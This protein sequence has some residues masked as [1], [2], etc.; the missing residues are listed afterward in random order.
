MRKHNPGW[1]R[2]KAADARRGQYILRRTKMKVIV[3][4]TYEE[5]AKIKSGI[6][7]VM[8]VLMSAI[9]VLLCYFFNEGIDV[10]LFQLGNQ[11]LY[12]IKA[13]NG[14]AILLMVSGMIHSKLLSHIGRHSKELMILHHPPFFFISSLSL[15]LSKLF[16]P[17]I[18]G[19]LI[20]TA[21]TTLFCL[22]IDQIMGRFRPYRF[23]MGKKK[24]NN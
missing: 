2:R 16:S 23:S 3:A 10:Q 21:A 19:A 20:I 15:L 6:R 18:F 1:F 7:I 22:A 4:D 8:I 11:W 12:F 14:T 5:G 9:Q 17:N 13:L 24:L